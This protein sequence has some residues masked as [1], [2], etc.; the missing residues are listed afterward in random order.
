MKQIEKSSHELLLP[1]IATPYA[2]K[3]WKGYVPTAKLLCSLQRSLW[4]GHTLARSRLSVMMFLSRHK[5]LC[6]YKP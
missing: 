2:E 6:L 5:M 4:I 1:S 3:S